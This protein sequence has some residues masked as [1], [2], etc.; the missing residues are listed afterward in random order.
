M[1]RSRPCAAVQ[2]IAAAGLSGF[3]PSRA[4][5]SHRQEAASIDRYISTAQRTLSMVSINLRTGLPIDGILDVLDKKLGTRDSTFRVTISLLDPARRGLMEA[6][7]P[8]LSLEPQ[9][10]SLDIANTVTKLLQ[11]RNSLED[12]VRPRLRLRLHAA[13]P[14]G[15][16]IM[17]D[18]LENDGRIQVETKAYRAP[19][20]KSFAF[21]LV[22]SGAD[23][24]LYHTLRVAYQQLIDDGRD[25]ESTSTA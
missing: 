3:Y 17:L 8:A 7:A 16:V 25:M 24:D 13:V 21:E 11:F 10:L 23:E 6:V 14:F 12:D 18:E 9:E 19:G 5:Y 2:L 20:R 22:S 15:S 1:I 4:Y